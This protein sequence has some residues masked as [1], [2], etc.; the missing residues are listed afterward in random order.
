MNTMKHLAAL[1]LALVIAGCAAGRESTFDAN[2]FRGHIAYLADDSLQGRGLGSQGIDEAADYIAEQFKAAGVKPMGDNGTYFQHFDAVLRRELEPATR[3]SVD[4][5]SLTLGKDFGPLP[6]SG[7][8]AF[9]APVVFGGYGISAPEFQYDDLA[10]V[11]LKG[12]ALLVF[13]Y[14]PNSDDPEDKFGGGVYTQHAY[15]QTKAALAHDKGAVA[16]LVVTPPLHRQEPDEIASF[17][18]GGARGS[19]SLPVIQVSQPVAE[20]M[21]KAGG[22]GD[23]AALESKIET[24]RK[25]Y[26]KPL[27]GVHVSGD[28]DIR[29]VRANAKN[30]VGLI[31]GTDKRSDEVLVIGAHYDHLGYERYSLPRN[32]EERNDPTKYIHNGADDNASGTSGLIELAKRIGEHP[33]KRSV[34]LIAFSGEETGLLGSEYYVEHPTVP[35]KREVA[36]LN[37][38]M[39]GALRDEKLTVFGVGTGAGFKDLVLVEAKRDG[40]TIEADEAGIGPSDHTSFYT[41][42]IPVLHFFTGSHDR[43]HRPD[44]DVEFIN[45]EGGAQVVQLIYDVAC[46]LADAPERPEYHEVKQKQE[47]RG[48][49]KVRMGI[50]PSYADDDEPGMKITG[51]TGDGPAE[52]AGLKAGDA[53]LMIGTSPVNNIY[54]YMG[55]LGRYNPGTTVLLKVARNGQELSI[56][57]TLGASK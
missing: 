30:V 13:R 16:L 44:D 8:G 1:L 18:T 41:R 32:E 46:E 14:E 47:S 50:M 24:E 3:M 28:I 52:K 7:T 34:L 19:V 29:R 56:P 31:P 51:V 21:L 40:L 36:M 4:G 37:M 6:V 39:I 45:A 55:V 9:S 35:L 42:G 20:R 33:F 10:G 48:G 49:L 26:A 5:Q 11:D 53:I 27:S 25:G 54:D 38:D 2:A 57:I 43:Y 15:Y 12:K 17:N 22:L 23:L